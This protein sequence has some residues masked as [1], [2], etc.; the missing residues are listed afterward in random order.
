MGLVWLGWG[1]GLGRR[2]FADGEDGGPLQGLVGDGGDVEA[3]EVGVFEAG[4]V[5]GE[6]GGVSWVLRYCVA[7]FAGMLGL[8]VSRESSKLEGGIL[9]AGAIGKRNVKHVQV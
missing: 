8:A 3:F 4:A 9:L 5:W 6:A 7:A 1:V 2:T